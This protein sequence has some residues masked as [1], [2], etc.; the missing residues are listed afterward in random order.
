MTSVTWI[1]LGF[2]FLFVPIGLIQA[3]VRDRVVLHSPEL[4]Q[5]VPQGTDLAVPGVRFTA[6]VWLEMIRGAK[7]S[8]DLAQFYVSQGLPS[9]KGGNAHPMTQIVNECEK[10]AE[11]G[12]QIRLLLSSTLLKEDVSTL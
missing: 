4:V 7:T 2:I 9:P 1:Y 3:Q 8:L 6:E 10:A 11:R 5:S 12:V